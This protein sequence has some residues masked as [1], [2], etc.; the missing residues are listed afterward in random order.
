MYFK[1]LIIFFIFTSCDY[2]EEKSIPKLYINI[3]SSKLEN[4]GPFLFYKNEKFN[5]YVVDFYNSTKIL[6]ISYLNGRK[7]GNEKIWFKNGRKSEERFYKNGR[8]EGKHLLY[9]KNNN[10]KMRAF[11]KNGKHEGEMIQWHEN[12]TKFKKFY[13]VNGNEVGNQKIWDSDGNIKANYDVINNRRYGLT[14]Q[15]NCISPNELL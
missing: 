11:F 10:L 2:Y 4:K 14:G 8:K 7:E 13:Y 9:W 5:G 12:G 1:I 3:K 6:E 15:K